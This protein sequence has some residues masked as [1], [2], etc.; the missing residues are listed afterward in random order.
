MP[1]YRAAILSGPRG[2]FAVVELPEHQ[3]RQLS[4]DDRR[5][6]THCLREQHG[7]IPVVFVTASPSTLHAIH[8]QEIETDLDACLSSHRAEAVPWMP[9]AH[10]A[11]GVD[12]R[13]V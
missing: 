1:H 5:A 8:G 11:D 9:F 3:Q 2:P 10:P 4:A 13:S 6:M 12:A 7:T